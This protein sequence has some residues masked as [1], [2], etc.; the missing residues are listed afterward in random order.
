MTKSILLLDP[1]DK[2]GFLSQKIPW[3]AFGGGGCLGLLFSV[4]LNLIS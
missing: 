4:K 1:K 2:D 3:A